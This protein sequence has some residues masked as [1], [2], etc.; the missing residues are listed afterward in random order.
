MQRRCGARCSSWR[1]PVRRPS[2]KHE[3]DPEIQCQ[4]TKV[5]WRFSVVTLIRFNFE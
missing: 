3:T 4:N 5:L 2:I 1:R